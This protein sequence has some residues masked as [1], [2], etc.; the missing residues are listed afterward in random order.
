MIRLWFVYIAGGRWRIL[1]ENKFRFVCNYGWNFLFVKRFYTFGK[2][3]YG[4]YVISIQREDKIHIY[5]YVC[6]WKPYF[7]KNIVFHV[8]FSNAM[9]ARAA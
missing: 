5:T 4:G 9:C 7:M 3:K 8:L 6:W 2:N 1:E